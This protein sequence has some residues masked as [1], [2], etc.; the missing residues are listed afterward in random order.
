MIT[1][2]AGLSSVFLLIMGIVWNRDNI[3]NV[4]VK[5]ICI[6]L[7]IW[8]LIATLQLSGYIIKP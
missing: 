3:T 6:G 1:F 7:G 8:G 5:I 4:V 2:Y